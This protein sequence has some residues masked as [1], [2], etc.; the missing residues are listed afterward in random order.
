[1]T[2]FTKMHGLGNDFVILDHLSGQVPLEP[3]WLRAVADR[4]TG[5]GCDQFL[6]IERG[7]H[8]PFRYRVFNADGGTAGQCGNGVRC[9]V[10]WLVDRG[11]AEG[12]ELE[13]ESPGG[14]VSARL[15]DDGLIAVEMGVP[16]FDPD[17]IPFIADR[18][19]PAYTLKLDGADQ[20][21]GAVSMGNPHLVLEVADVQRAPVATLGP[22]LERHPRFPDRANVGFMQITARDHMQLRVY[23][24]GTGETL[25]CGSGACAA[26]AVA[27]TW[28]RVDDEVAVDLPGGRLMVSWTGEPDAPVWMTGPATEVFRGELA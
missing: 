4:H 24:R 9:V 14:R 17:D 26:V 13:L 6:V 11:L 21:I 28:E 3:E 1:M 2:A 5:V 27:R 18:R 23:E 25:A 8:A 22:R 15:M 20:R 16:H 10:K 19:E 7:A 12:P